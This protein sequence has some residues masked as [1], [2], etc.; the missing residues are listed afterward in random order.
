MLSPT[1]LKPLS[2]SI[3]FLFRVSLSLSLSLLSLSLSLSLSP[4]SI[5]SKAAL[6]HANLSSF[7]VCSGV[8]SF[9]RVCCYD[10]CLCCCCC[11]C[12]LLLLLPPPASREIL[13]TA[14]PFL[15]MK[16]EEPDRYLRLEHWLQKGA[17]I[18][19]RDLY[20]AGSSKEKRRAEIANMLIPEVRLCVLHWVPVVCTHL[21]ERI[22]S[23][24]VR[25]T[26]FVFTS[27]ATSAPLFS[28]RGSHRGAP[29]GE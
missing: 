20:P 23:F 5:V 24:I 27:Q 29:V 13:R 16:K 14:D 25:K 12:Y 19:P 4:P 10:H 11:C 1:R 7:T 6:Y 9:R 3:S 21:R 22:G 15:Q 2:T 8:V 18:D 17:A 26:H 28:H